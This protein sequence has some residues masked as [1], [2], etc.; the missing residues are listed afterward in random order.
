MT[1]LWIVLG[2]VAGMGLLLVVISL[3]SKAALAAIKGPIERR[4]AARLT[5][6]DILFREV[7]ANSLGVESKGKFQSRGNGGL[8]LTA[9]TLHFFQLIPESELQIPLSSVREVSLVRWHLGKTVGYRLLKVRYDTPQ[10]SDSVAWF[11]P[12]PDAWVQRLRAPT[13]APV[14]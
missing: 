11:V 8:V 14:S 10:G 6:A 12:D 7:G 4:I 9:T 1:A 13:E 2:C 3:A 5:D